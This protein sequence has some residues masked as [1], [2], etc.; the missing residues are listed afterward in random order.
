MMNNIITEK[1]NQQLEMVRK[2]MI[3]QDHLSSSLFDKDLCLLSKV[4]KKLLE[5]A[6]LLEKKLLVPIVNAHV[7]DVLLCGDLASFVY[8]KDSPIE[9]A[10]VVNDYCGDKELTLKI[11]HIFN[12]SFYR[13]GF[14]FKINDRFVKYYFT[15]PDQI[16]GPRFSLTDNC[17]REKPVHRQ[18]S[19]SPAFCFHQYYLLSQQLHRFVGSLS[20]T[21]NANLTL[22][23]CDA[24]SAYLDNLKNETLNF[25]IEDSDPVYSLKRCLF[26]CLKT[27]GAYDHF[28]HYILQSRLYHIN[29]GIK[30]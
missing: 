23:A 14:E 15:L 28:R 5:I 11:M 7:S 3:V 30:K 22:P 29:Q 4:A 13:R 18:F 12:K 9:L 10:I 1:H 6:Q 20:K 25:Q 19:F 24:L 16:T 8:H 17:W 26:R 21:G 2:L 27:F